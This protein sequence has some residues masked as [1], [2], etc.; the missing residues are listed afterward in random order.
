MPP[1]K[2]RR[3]SRR[4]PTD[5]QP[6]SSKPV[7]AITPAEADRQGLSGDVASGAGLEGETEL[8]QLTLQSRLDVAQAHVVVSDL[9]RK[10]HT[11]ESPVV[12]DNARAHFGDVNTIYNFNQSSPEAPVNSEKPDLMKALSFNGMSDRLMGITPAYAETCHWILDS[13]EYL[14]W[15]DP[16]Q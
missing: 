6:P 7:T 4:P 16:S 11:Y 14:R 12:K 1:R 15:R 10:G 5:P 8:G 13:P 3:K 2:R 9:G